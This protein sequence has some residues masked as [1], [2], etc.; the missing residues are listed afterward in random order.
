MGVAAAGRGVHETV[1]ARWCVVVAL[2]VSETLL[3]IVTDLWALPKT[4][5]AD[6]ITNRLQE[7]FY[8]RCPPQQRPAFLQEDAT[9]AEDA[10]SDS[11]TVNEKDKSEKAETP[12]PDLEQAKTK[13]TKTKTE[14]KHDASLVKAINRSYFWYIWGS[15]LMRLGAGAFPILEL[16]GLALISVFRAGMLDVTSPLVTRVLL[17]WVTESYIYA[18]LP[19]ELRATVPAPPGVGYGVGVAFGLFAMLREFEPFLS[20]DIVL[21]V[22]QRPPASYVFSHG[23]EYHTDPHKLMN[24]HNQ[25]T[26]PPQPV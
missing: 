12:T 6:H 20:P 7:N 3:N 9:T 10:D 24:H 16:Q 18:R 2:G 4:R 21:T 17:N 14:P 8:K 1:G 11:L 19:E 25:S 15:G 26:L 23:R 5:E 22:S 13:A